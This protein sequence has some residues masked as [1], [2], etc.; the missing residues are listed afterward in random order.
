[1]QGKTY[2]ER[3]EYLDAEFRERGACAWITD[4]PDPE[5]DD[6][7]IGQGDVRAA[8]YMSRKEAENALELVLGAYE[9]GYEEGERTGH[10]DAYDVARRAGYADGYDDGWDAKQAEQNETVMISEETILQTYEDTNAETFRDFIR[11]ID[12]DTKKLD[13]IAIRRENRGNMI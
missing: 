1:M 13:I 10:D 2:Q 4:D 8:P 9:T 12:P 5:G 11:E 6:M 3:L 7:F